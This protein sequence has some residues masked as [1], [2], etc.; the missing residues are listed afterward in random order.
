MKA[1]KVE[2][3]RQNGTIYPIRLRLPFSHI[4]NPTPHTT[5]QADDFVRFTTI[6]GVEVSMDLFV[7]DCFL[8]TSRVVDGVQK[9]E[10]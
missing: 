7:L 1:L 9:D 10:L 2:R 6:D 5:A 8:P 4:D 3:S